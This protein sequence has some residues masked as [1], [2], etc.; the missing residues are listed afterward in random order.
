MEQFERFKTLIGENSL[1]K[2]SN[3]KV[4]IF[5]VGGVGGYIIEALARSGVGKIDIVDNDTI[6]L[7]NINRQIIALHS[8]LNK[9]KVDVMKERILDINP[10]AKVETFEIFFNDSKFEENYR[11]TDF[12]N[13]RK[14]INVESR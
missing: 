7:T 12:E 5:G 3:S 11:D 10:K 14:I 1:E 6:N 13:V 9:S 2:L 8:T 4:I